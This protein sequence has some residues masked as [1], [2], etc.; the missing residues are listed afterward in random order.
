[1][2]EM[3]KVITE[4][5]ASH[6]ELNEKKLKKSIKSNEMMQLHIDDKLF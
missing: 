6:C 1:M 2:R 4:N 5:V 3:T